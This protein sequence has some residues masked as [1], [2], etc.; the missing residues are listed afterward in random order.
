MDREVDKNAL[1]KALRFCYGETITVGAK[2]G[3]CFALLSTFSK[4]QVTCFDDVA[5]QL[6]AFAIQQAQEDVFK[7][8]EMLKECVCYEECC[9]THTCRLNKE[10]AKVVLTKENITSH[11]REVVDECLML[12]PP[13]YMNMAEFGDLHTRYSEF[14]LRTKYLRHNKSMTK[15]EQKAF[16]CNCDWSTL[17]SQELRELK[18]VGIVEMNDILEAYERALENCENEKDKMEKEMI[19]EK[20]KIE[21]E[22]KEVIERNRLLSQKHSEIP[23]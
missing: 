10:L 9:D 3:E 20:E 13:E 2:D 11:Y 12:L 8:V 19:E 21:K 15:E 18:L 22:K 16:L 17:N 1:I 14:C 4:L 6:S 23:I 7:G 5:R